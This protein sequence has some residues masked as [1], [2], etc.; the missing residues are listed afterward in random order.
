MIT[1]VIF[2][3]NVYR[4]VHM[5]CVDYQFGRYTFD[6]YF[7]LLTFLTTYINLNCNMIRL[8][9]HVILRFDKV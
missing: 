2:L 7:H 3:P 9:Y 6:Y 4:Q 1:E 8:V 5:C